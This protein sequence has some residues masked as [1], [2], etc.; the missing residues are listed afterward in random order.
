MHWLYE[1]LF[2]LTGFRKR[3]MD[4]FQRLL[5]LDP[6][7]RIIDIGGTF[8]NW[9]YVQVTPRITLLNLD[10]NHATRAYPENVRYHAGN[11]LDL[12]FNDGDFDI[13]FS[14]SVIEHV[15]TWENQT[16]FAEEA[17]RVARKLWIQTPAREFFIEPHLL[18]PFV[19]WAPVSAQKKLLR[20]F[21]VWG[22]IRRPTPTQVDAFLAEVRLLTYAEMKD[23][24]PDCEILV[25]RWL[26]MPKAYIAFRS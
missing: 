4:R 21:T 23:L 1:H 9:K 2:K 3:R 5:R 22:W 11:A 16:R 12:P 26:G 24:F 25:E 15:S 18:A 17:R 10:P 20:N 14:N 7:T 6:A 19:H 13:V 8:G